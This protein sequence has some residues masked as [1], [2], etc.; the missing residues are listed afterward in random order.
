MRNRTMNIADFEQLFAQW[1]RRSIQGIA[2]LKALSPVDAEGAL[3]K[4]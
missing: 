1:A 4:R 2:E 3:R